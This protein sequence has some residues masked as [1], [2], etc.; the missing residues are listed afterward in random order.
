MRP[1]VKIYKV[2]EGLKQ[3][4]KETNIEGSKESDMEWPEE[5]GSHILRGQYLVSVL[6]HWYD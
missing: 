6:F 3:N 1:L 2:K 4:S 5:R